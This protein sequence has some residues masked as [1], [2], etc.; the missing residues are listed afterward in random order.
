M[1]TSIRPWL[2]LALLLT[3]GACAPAAPPATPTP[4]PIRAVY[5]VSGQAVLTPSDVQAHPEILVVH[6]F[7]EL[8]AHAQQQGGHLDRQ[9]RHAF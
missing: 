8:A 7:D 3:L 1:N 6:S 9:E 5:L 2:L 4:V